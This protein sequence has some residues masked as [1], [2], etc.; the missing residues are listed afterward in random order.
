[1]RPNPRSPLQ[2]R[3]GFFWITSA[4]RPQPFKTGRG[5]VLQQTYEVLLNAPSA[6]ATGGCSR[7]P[8]CPVLCLSIPPARSCRCQ[9][10]R[11]QVPPSPQCSTDAFL[12]ASFLSRSHCCHPALLV[13]RHS[14]R[15]RRCG[16]CPLSFVAVP[17][18]SSSHRSVGCL[19]VTA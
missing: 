12:G 3:L 15:R 4:F 2:L 11:P 5:R 7:L 19:G 16:H 17:P 8:S 9:P 6:T 1:M 13:V 14:S 18:A 10:S